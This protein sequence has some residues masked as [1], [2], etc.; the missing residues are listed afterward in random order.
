M[1][2]MPVQEITVSEAASYSANPDISLDFEPKEWLIVN[3][4]TTVTHY[5]YFSFDGQND[6]GK[7]IP[8]SPIAGCSYKNRAKKLWLRA[9]TGGGGTTVSAIVMASTEV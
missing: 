2:A 6:H 3:L 8:G 4:N 1:P 7:L 5:L 9:S